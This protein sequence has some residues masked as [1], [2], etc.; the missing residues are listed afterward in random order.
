V[1]CGTGAG[2]VYSDYLEIKD[3]VVSEHPVNDYQPGS[4]RD[5]FEFGVLMLLSRKAVEDALR[6][7]GTIHDVKWAGLYDLRLKVSLDYHLMRIPELLYTKVETDVRL[8]GEKQFD[9]V[10]PRNQNVQTEMEI[11]ATEHLKRLGSYL[12][13]VFEN[14]PESNIR[15]PVEAS[16][17]IPVRNREKTVGDAVQS[18]FGQKTQ[19][20]YNILVVDNHSTDR[21]TQIL[22]DFAAK[23]PRVRHIVPTRKDLGIG[24]CWNEAVSSEFCGRYAVQ[25]DSDDLY[26]DGTTLQQIV[27]KFKQGNYAMVIGSYRMVNF[28]LE[29]IPPGVIDHREWT[30]ENGRNNALRVNGFG[31]PRGFHTSLLRAHPMPNVSYGEDYAVG[32]RLSRHY[33]IGRIFDPIYLC[34]RWEGNTDAVLSIAS[35]NNYNN[36]KDTLRTIEITARQKTN[37]EKM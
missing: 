18:V 12:A 3:G 21:T 26:A 29:E 31:A 13:P 8:S 9:Y 23:N 33:E 7:Y 20:D 19:F 4:I 1:A 28:Q 14:V 5:N 17:I 36:Y 15:F 34:R 16:V 30:R 24:G 6:R 10:D 11:V 27:D 25:L 37:K 22:A 2:I 35:S 32:L